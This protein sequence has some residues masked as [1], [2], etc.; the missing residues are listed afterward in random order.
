MNCF[1]NLKDVKFNPKE[2]NP[3]Q[4]FIEH[5]NLISVQLTMNQ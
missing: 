3:H 5:M 4:W 1:D 2:Y